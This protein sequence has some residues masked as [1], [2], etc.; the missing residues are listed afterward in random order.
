V[1]TWEDDSTAGHY[2]PA[3]SR[4]AFWA[5]VASTV[6]LLFGST[7][8]RLLR[9]GPLGAT[10]SDEGLLVTLAFEVTLGVFWVRRLQLQGWSLLAVTEPFTLGDLGWGLVLYAGTLLSYWFAFAA[11]ALVVPPFAEAARHVAL[12]GRAI[13]VV[14]LLLVLINPVAEE[15]LYLG[16]IAATLRR[17]DA[18]LALSASTLARVAVH[19]YQGPLGIVSTLPTGLILGSYYLRSRRI[20]PTVI[21]HALVDAIA[22]SR[23]A[24]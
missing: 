20:W 3:M 5:L 16:V 18:L 6:G 7:L 1:S 24:A 23:L 13:P 14:A 8:L 12:G 22:L 17:Q 19:L 4:V 15:F 11:V 9:G 2:P 21:A 10:F